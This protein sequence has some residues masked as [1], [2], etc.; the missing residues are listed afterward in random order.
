MTAEDM[1]RVS[2]TTAKT[3]ERMRRVG[4]VTT[5]EGMITVS[6]VTTDTTTVCDVTTDMRTVCDVT[7]V[8][9]TTVD[10]TTAEDMTMRVSV[11]VE[12]MMTVG[13][14]VEGTTRVSGA[15]TVDM[16]TAEGM[17]TADDLTAEDMTAEDMTRVSA[18][19]RGSEN[20]RSGKEEAW[21]ETADKD[22]RD[23]STCTIPDCLRNRPCRL[24][25]A[26][27]R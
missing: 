3:V 10:V 14:T 20:P 4:D 1:T 18:A 21:S 9:V 5:A 27:G 15:K 19:T 25:T 16:T 2:A 23:T 17:M 26:W 13:V 24:V 22:P 6:D 7:T 11:T 8:D 12:D